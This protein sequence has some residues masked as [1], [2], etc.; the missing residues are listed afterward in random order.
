MNSLDSL[1]SLSLSY[2]STIDGGSLHSNFGI[3]SFIINLLIGFIL[4]CCFIF[5]FAYVS[6]NFISNNYIKIPAFDRYVINR[7]NELRK[8]P[9]PG[10]RPPPG[11]RPPQ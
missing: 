8:G 2:I 6:L 1:D 11:P 10:S 3:V 4:I 9:P 5:I 7:S